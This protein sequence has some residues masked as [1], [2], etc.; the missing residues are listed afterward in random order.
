MY[1]LL[2]KLILLLYWFTRFEWGFDE[3]FDGEGWVVYE[4]GFYVCG[5][6]GFY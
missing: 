4:L 5:Y 1:V 6:R 3:F 2:R